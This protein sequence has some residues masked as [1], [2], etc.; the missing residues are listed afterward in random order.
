MPVPA[1]GDARMASFVVGGQ[2][3]PTVHLALRDNPAVDPIGYAYP[4]LAAMSCALR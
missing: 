3:R 2:A 1:A 4:R